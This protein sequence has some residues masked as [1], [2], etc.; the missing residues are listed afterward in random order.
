MG[1]RI[2]AM[3][4]SAARRVEHHPVDVAALNPEDPTY[5]GNLAVDGE[6]GRVLLPR[7]FVEAHGLAEDQVE[8]YWVGD[9]LILLPDRHRE[10]AAR[11]LSEV[12]TADAYAEDVGPADA[13]DA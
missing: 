1:R 13:D 9:A 12:L 4:D 5:V 3:S 7:A 6:A 2:V 10:A 8:A 11:Y